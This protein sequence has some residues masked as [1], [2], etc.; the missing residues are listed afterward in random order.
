MDQKTHLDI[1]HCPKYEQ[2]PLA[3]RVGLPP[4]CRMPPPNSNFRRHWYRQLAFHSNKYTYSR[5]YIP[6]Q[7]DT[8]LQ[9]TEL[10]HNQ[11]HQF[12]LGRI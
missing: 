9:Q 7:D 2:Y 6:R 10:Y 1:V 4:P 12:L 11:P 8:I 3:R 5:R